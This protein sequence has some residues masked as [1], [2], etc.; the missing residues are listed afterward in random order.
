MLEYVTTAIAVCKAALGTL[1]WT[2]EK[3]EAKSFSEADN[4]ILRAAADQG[5][6]QI[7]KASSLLTV[8]AGRTDFQRNDPAYGARYLDAFMELCDKGLVTYHD[9]D[10]FCL[11]SK[12]FEIARALPKWIPPEP[13]TEDE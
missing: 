4:D 2:K 5:I 12:G 10:L 7:V 1:K 11:N 9:D 3:Y 8:F 6:I 13:E